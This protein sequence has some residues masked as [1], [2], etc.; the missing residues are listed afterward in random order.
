MKI[1][2]RVRRQSAEQENILAKYLMKKLMSNVFE[3]T[4]QQQNANWP[5]YKRA[6][7]L[8]KCFPVGQQETKVLTPSAISKMQAEATRRFT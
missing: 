4:T 5:S 8:T 1:S 7:D 2:H 6:G 3:T